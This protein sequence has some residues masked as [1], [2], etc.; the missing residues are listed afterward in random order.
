MSFAKKSD[1]KYHPSPRVRAT[2]YFCVS[3]ND[4]DPSGY[5]MPGSVISEVDAIQA[6]PSD[7]AADFFAEHSS[8][9]A[10]DTPAEPLTGAKNCPMCRSVRQLAPTAARSAQ[11]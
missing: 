5:A 11:A 7:F 6:D 1:V 8:P 3:V 10:V 4:P 2:A 9:A